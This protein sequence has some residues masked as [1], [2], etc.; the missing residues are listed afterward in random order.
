MCLPSF[1]RLKIRHEDILEI[2]VEFAH[3]FD[4]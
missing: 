1:T 3:I 4:I 2:I